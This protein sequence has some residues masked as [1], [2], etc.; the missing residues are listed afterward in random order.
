L[1]SANS[2][3]VPGGATADDGYVECLIGHTSSDCSDRGSS[4]RLGGEPH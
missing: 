2:A 4:R 3:D 1:G